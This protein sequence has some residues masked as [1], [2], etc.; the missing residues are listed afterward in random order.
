MIRME[1]A[2]IDAFV[3]E[4]WWYCGAL[5]FGFAEEYRELLDSGH[6]NISSIIPGK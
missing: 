4:A 5:F 6:G 2:H 1:C 3:G